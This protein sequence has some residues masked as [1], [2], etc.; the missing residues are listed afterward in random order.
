MSMLFVVVEEECV[1]L[2]LCMCVYVCAHRSALFRTTHG[3]LPLDRVALILVRY[4]VHFGIKQM[5]IDALDLQSL[6]IRS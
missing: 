2:C 6:E 4:I 1:C 5:N 3:K